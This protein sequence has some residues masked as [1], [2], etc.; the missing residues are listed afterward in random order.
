MLLL[1]TESE[2]PGASLG[3]VFSSAP[4]HLPQQPYTS[5]VGNFRSNYFVDLAFE[6]LEDQKK[7]AGGA[8]WVVAEMKNSFWSY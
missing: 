2:S 3:T 5:L 1:Q 8:D 7:T 4:S 6:E